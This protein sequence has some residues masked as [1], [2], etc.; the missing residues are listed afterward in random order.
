MF[1]VDVDGLVWGERKICG[2][3]RETIFFTR[4]RALQC[5]DATNVRLDVGQ[6]GLGGL[7]A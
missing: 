4:T 5:L 2:E 6:P 7:T 1:V 3:R